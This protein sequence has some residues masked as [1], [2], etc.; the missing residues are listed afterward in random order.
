MSTPSPDPCSASFFHRPPPSSSPAPG[1]SGSPT[2]LLGFGS[3]SG[4]L[5]NTEIAIFVNLAF[6]LV[7]SFLCFLLTEQRRREHRGHPK[8]IHRDI[9]PSNI[10]LD[11]N[12]E[13]KIA[14]FGIAKLAPEGSHVRTLPHGTIGYLDPESFATGFVTDKT[15]VYSFGVMLLELITGRRAVDRTREYPESSLVASAR[16]ELGQV[17]EN[18]NGNLRELVDPRLRNYTLIEMIRLIACA[19]YCVQESETKRPTM[20]RVE[21]VI[22]GESSNLRHHEAFWGCL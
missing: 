11:S 18:G 17:I 21:L 8:I 20:K 14:D 12:F 16:R 3:G 2:Y 6:F 22:P 5:F 15:D 1:S 13:P 10:L 9:K 19:Y 4:S 7:S